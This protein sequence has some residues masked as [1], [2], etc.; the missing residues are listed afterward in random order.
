MAESEPAAASRVSVAQKCPGF[1]P[2]AKI[3]RSEPVVAAVLS[4]FATPVLI[5]AG[6][7][8]SILSRRSPFIAHLRVGTGGVPFW[9]WKLRTMW[10]TSSPPEGSWTFVE[11]I[12]GTEIPEDKIEPDPR[13]SSRFALF[14]RVHSID[15]LPQLFH[16]LFTQMSLVGPRPIT[17][18]ELDR[19]Y[20]SSADEVLRMRPGLTGLWQVSGRNALSYAERRKL[21][22]EL[23]GRFNVRLYFTILLRTIPKLISGAS[24]R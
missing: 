14:C 15:E 22:L 10:D 4:L 7:T 21:D 3:Y 6:A 9:M 1:S 2:A 18:E 5:A 11:R 16:V 24:R 23:A 17:R 8:I 19:Y 20:G 12:S 13:V